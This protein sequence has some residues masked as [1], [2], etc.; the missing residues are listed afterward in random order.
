MKN[1]D[2]YNWCNNKTTKTIKT[3][4]DANA[5]SQS[6]LKQIKKT[7]AH[8][9]RTYKKKIKR[10]ITITSEPLYKFSYKHITLIDELYGKLYA[11]GSDGDNIL[12]L[13][14]EKLSKPHKYWDFSAFEISFDEQ[15]MTFCVDTTGDKVSQLYY[16]FFF[17]DKIH[18][19]INPDGHKIISYHSYGGTV[20]ISKNSNI[21]FYLTIDKNTTHKSRMVL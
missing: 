10:K 20:A 11:V 15:L 9:A 17:N 1:I 13:N 19:I 12:I 5:K 2:N 16:K 14:K 21:I 4:D 7:T 18:E 3:I 8:L 6:F